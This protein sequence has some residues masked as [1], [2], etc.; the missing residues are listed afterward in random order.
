MVKAKNKNANSI[1]QKRPSLNM[2]SCV[3]VPY[4]ARY[5]ILTVIILAGMMVVLAT[6]FAATTNTEDIIK[7]KI[8]EITAD[9]Y[10]NYYYDK[11]ISAVTAEKPLSE[12]MSLYEKY[13]LNPISMEQL[14]LR[15]EKKYPA[16]TAA[17]STYC[18][19]KATTVRIYPNSPFGR[20]DYHVDYRYSCNF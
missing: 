3:K 1:H 12:I 13:G 20:T 19:I 8:T 18:D 5:T 9:Y 10:E 11:I 6:F 15:D 17:I 7:G 2:H 14:L 16:S 4:F